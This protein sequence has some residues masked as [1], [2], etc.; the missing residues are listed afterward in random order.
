[1]DT[2]TDGHKSEVGLSLCFLLFFVL[3]FSLF[4]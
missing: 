3:A 2:D 1:M 4:T